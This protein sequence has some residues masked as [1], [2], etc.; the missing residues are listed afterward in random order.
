MVKRLMSPPD[1]NIGPIAPPGLQGPGALSTGPIAPPESL[2]IRAFVDDI[3]L[4]PWGICPER[5]IPPAV[6]GAWGHCPESFQ[7]GR[8][9]RRWESISSRPSCRDVEGWK[10]IPD[11]KR[12]L[13]PVLHTSR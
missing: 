12:F 10:T 1:N 13:R 5:D 7:D 6:D 3:F 4:L 2:P 11:R 8:V 9:F